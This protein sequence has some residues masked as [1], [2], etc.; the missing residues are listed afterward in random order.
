MTPVIDVPSQSPTLKCFDDSRLRQQPNIAAVPVSLPVETAT[1]PATSVGVAEKVDEYQHVPFK[2]A[3]TRS[4]RYVRVSPL[5]PRKV[6]IEAE[7]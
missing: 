4:V 5:K 3:G 1:E 6:S 2:K 7:G